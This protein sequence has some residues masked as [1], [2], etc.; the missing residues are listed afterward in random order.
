MDPGFAGRSGFDRRVDSLQNNSKDVNPNK[1]K[2]QDFYANLARESQTPAVDKTPDQPQMSA[3]DAINAIQD[4]LNNPA[5]MRKAQEV[6][7]KSDS[8]SGERQGVVGSTS[9]SDSAKKGP[10]ATDLKTNGA[11][12]DSTSVKKG[13]GKGVGSNIEGSKLGA[14]G[15]SDHEYR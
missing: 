15:Q 6:L 5:W 9:S 8:S 11:I 10:S 12:S 4:L 3:K 7:K 13:F 14:L 2:R 1:F